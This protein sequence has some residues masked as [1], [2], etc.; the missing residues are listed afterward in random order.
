[1]P[2]TEE[3]T[4]FPTAVG[5]LRALI[6]EP[7]DAAGPLP[8]I[9]IVDGS[10][11]G[12]ADDWGEWPARFVNAGAVVL[13]HDKPGCGGSPGDWTAQTFTDRAY[14]SLAALDLLRA[15]PSVQ[16]RS[17]GLL[18]FSQG[19]WVSLLAATLRPET[20]DFVISLSGPGVSPAEQERV[21]IERTLRAAG[22][23]PQGV[24]EA[25]T[26]IDERTRRLLA[27]EDV[28]TVLADQERLAERA[29]YGPATEYF[30]NL[31]APGFLARALNFDPVPVLQ[32]VRCPVLALFGAADSL[33]PVASS[34]AAFAR[35]LPESAQNGIAIFPDAD[36]GLFTAEPDPQV[37]RTDQLAAG[38]L[39]MIKSFLDGRPSA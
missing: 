34:V 21:R 15:H 8:G 16:G 20:V 26:W 39:P 38:F 28:A 7:A 30:D 25:M 36:H 24:V 33:V 31:A 27:G 37:P 23:S 10:G 5:E 13:T 12:A 29:W 2:T 18:G 32:S 35:H 19:G 14:E 22:I 3:W 1:M 17:V 11:D 9:V 4:T 6:H